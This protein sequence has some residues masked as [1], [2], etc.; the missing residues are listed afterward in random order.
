MLGHGLSWPFV[1]LQIWRA[2]GA[3]EPA[4][5]A[6]LVANHISHFDSLFLAIAFDR[7]IDWMTT[8]E[9]MGPAG[10]GWAARGQYFSGGPKAHFGY[11]MIP[12]AMEWLGARH[13]LAPGRF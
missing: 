9:S 4:G 3:V 1:R 11:G 8:K 10:G 2:P 13:L 7:T 12:E 5:A 6:V